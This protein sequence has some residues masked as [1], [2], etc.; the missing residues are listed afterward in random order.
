[1]RNEATPL[2][3]VIGPA[4]AAKRKLFQCAAR[5][6]GNTAESSGTVPL[7]PETHSSS[8]NIHLTVTNQPVKKAIPAASFLAKMVGLLAE[9]LVSMM[10]LDKLQD[11]G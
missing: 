3:D 8:R 1:M 10:N 4:P 2:A 7:P 5:R 11:N 6:N 9:A